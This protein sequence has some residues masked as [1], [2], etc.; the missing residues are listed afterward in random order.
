MGIGLAVARRMASLG[1]DISI[2]ARRQEPLVQAAAE[3][4]RDLKRAAQRV[5]YWQLDVADQA[6]VANVMQ[7]AVAKAGVPDVLVNCAGRAYP[8]YFENISYEQF[9]DTMRVN[10]HG[11]WNT[12][13]ALVPRMKEKGGYIVN[14][15]SVAGLLGVFGY[16]DYC[17]SK[18]ALV[19]FSEALR[20]ELRR[21]GIVVSV[22][23]PPDTLTP[24]LEKENETKPKETRA[25]AEGAKIMSTE[26]VAGALI[27]GM[28]KE[29]FII[30]PGVD[31]RFA[32][33]AKR[34]F[35]GLLEKL[36]DRRIR[37]AAGVP[38]ARTRGT[39]RGERGL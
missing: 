6:Q 22:L 2:F 33:L 35:P 36:I 18:F 8:D 15:S 28:S 39:Q 25:V 14:T 32:I 20:S 37:R 11:C 34:L 29:S 30:I 26:D 4:E 31:G 10:V 12:V 19:G 1:A 5:S 7:A 3:I 13:S 9:A 27:A 17:A 21:Y 23:C 24:G 16:T 38:P